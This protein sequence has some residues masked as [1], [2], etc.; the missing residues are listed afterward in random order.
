VTW[1]SN[2]RRRLFV[3]ELGNDSSVFR[4]QVLSARIGDARV[5][6]FRIRIGRE[7]RGAA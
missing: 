2:D 7:I 5:A 4:W 6:F 3:A 1:T